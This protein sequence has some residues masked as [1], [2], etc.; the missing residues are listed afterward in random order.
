M[1]M[2]EQ[3]S[4]ERVFT[5][6]VSVELTGTLTLPAKNGTPSSVAMTGRSTIVYDEKLL[7]PLPDGTAR[8]IRVYRQADFRRTMNEQTQETTIRPAVRRMVVL[9]NGTREA[10]FSPDGPLTFGEINIVSTDV[11]P[12]A[13]VGMLPAQPVTVGD[14]WPAAL[15]AVE[16]ITDFER[17]EQGGLTCRLVGVDGRTAKVT[18]TGTVTGVNEDGPVRQ[19]LDGQF[20]F[21]LDTNLITALNFTGL[22]SLLD[23]QG[24]TTGRIEGKFSLTRKL[25][26]VA[27]LSEPRLR[28]LT[29]EPNATNTLLCYEG[30][31]AHIRFTY[32]RRWRVSAEQGRQIT[33]DGPQGNGLLITIEPSEKVP[34][35]T[36]YVREA[37]DYVVKQKGRVVKADPPQ[38]L[39]PYPQELDRCGMDIEMNNQPARMEYAVVRQSAGGATLAARLLPPDA[40]TLRLEVEQIAKSIQIGPAA[41][42]G[43][44]PLPGK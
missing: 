17:V 20:T 43:V 7:P 21:D 16:E 33:L 5:I 34:A 11:Y 9:R 24:K 36:E 42:V 32:P 10:P 25:A 22:K 13:L 6:H 12:S 39:R 8:S 44:V 40:V 19:Q 35:I 41:P 15:S 1:A 29:L 28:G 4:P 23:G 31:G 38:K 26:D 27:D 3:F 2:R 14:T 30:A 37:T 18:F